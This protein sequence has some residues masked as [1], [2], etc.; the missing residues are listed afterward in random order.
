MDKIEAVKGKLP[1]PLYK[2]REFLFVLINGERLDEYIANHVSNDYRGLIPSWLDFY[3]KDYEPR[4]R[5]KEFVWAQIRLDE[6]IKILPILLCPDDFDFSCTVVVVEVI[7]E[8]DT[9]IWNRVGVDV[10]KFN[11]DKEGVFKYIGDTVEW[12]DD[13]RPHVFSKSEYINCVDAFIQWNEEQYKYY[14]VN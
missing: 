1:F 5:E 12:F 7:S 4:K 2:D 6:K 11:P 9:V 8:I 13:I 14:E 3:S 10:S